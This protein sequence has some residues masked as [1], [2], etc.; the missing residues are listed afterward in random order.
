MEQNYHIFHGIEI[1]II[2]MR[3]ADQARPVKKLIEGKILALIIEKFLTRLKGDL[4]KTVKILA[5]LKHD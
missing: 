1:S 5:F 2:T 4:S 3:P